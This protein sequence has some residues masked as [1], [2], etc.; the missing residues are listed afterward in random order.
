MKNKKCK[1][2][3]C[4]NRETCEKE[5][6]EQIEVSETWEKFLEDIIQF[7]KELK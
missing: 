6:K 4:K 1:C 2:K 3:N 7:K 5:D